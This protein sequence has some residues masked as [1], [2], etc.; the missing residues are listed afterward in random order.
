[1]LLINSVYLLISLLIL[2][3]YTVGILR[4][5]NNFLL[6]PADVSPFSLNTHPPIPYVELPS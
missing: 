6:T 3:R 2:R 1:M 4:T 5:S